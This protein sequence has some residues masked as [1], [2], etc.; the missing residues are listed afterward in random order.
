MRVHPSLTHIRE[1]RKQTSVETQQSSSDQRVCDEILPR[2]DKILSSQKTTVPQQHHKTVLPL[3]QWPWYPNQC[4]WR[5]PATG[6]HRGREPEEPD[7]DLGNWCVLSAEMDREIRTLSDGVRRA[8]RCPVCLELPCAVSA[9]C[10]N[11]HSTCDNCA[12]TLF[13]MERRDVQPACPLCRSPMFR[14]SQFVD[15]DP[16]YQQRRT[17]QQPPTA[18]KVYEL[19][20]ITRVTCS[21]RTEGCPDLVF[22][23]QV[24]EHEAFCPHV[25]KV[26]CMAPWCQWL[27]AYEQAFEHVASE[28]Q[29]CAYDVPVRYKPFKLYNTVIFRQRELVTFLANLQTL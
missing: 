16:G 4:L 14:P 13:Q 1:R 18:Q 8:L 23:P 22:V 20:S 7:A 2:A 26:R 5:Q 21:F 27:G 6:D 3:L 19:M 15:D 29:F 9:C 10:V 17:A 25:P 28:H 24:A 12:A 11:G